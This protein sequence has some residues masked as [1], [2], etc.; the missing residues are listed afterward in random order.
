MK[1]KGKLKE[2]LKSPWLLGVIG[3]VF[4]SLI[5]NGFLIG[6]SILHPHSLVAKDYYEKGKKYF[7]ESAILKSDASKLGYKMNLMVPD[8]L[9]VNEKN[10]IRLSIVDKTGRPVNSG[11]VK[12]F[13]YRSDNMKQDFNITMEKSD[14][15][16]YE[17]PVIFDLPGVWDLIAQISVSGEKMDVAKRIFVNK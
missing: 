9:K 6:F 16:F 14:G 7:H 10:H 3:T 8:G 2:D 5:A 4:V 1:S 12:L 11:E 17:S 13:V 15:S